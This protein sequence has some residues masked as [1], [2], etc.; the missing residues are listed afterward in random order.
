M[1]AAMMV[2][3]LV[4]KMVVLMVALR[5]SQWVASKAVRKVEKLDSELA[6]RKV[7]QMAD[8]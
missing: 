3:S 2:W 7:A 8:Q 1:M 5:E 4:G 6:V